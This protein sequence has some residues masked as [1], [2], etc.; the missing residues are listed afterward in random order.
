MEIGEDI[1]LRP[2][3]TIHLNCDH[4]TALRV[5]NK[6]NEDPGDFIVSRLDNHVFIKPQKKSSIFGLHS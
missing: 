3:F 6:N 1:V 4:E 2:R 5:F